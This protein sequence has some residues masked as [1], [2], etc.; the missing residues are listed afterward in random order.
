[1]KIIFN[2]SYTN[3][4]LKKNAYFFILL[5]FISNASHSQERCGTVP[6]SL[7]NRKI[8]VINERDVQFEQWLVEKIKFRKDLEKEKRVVA[9]SHKIQVI[10]HIIH[11]G[12]SVGAGTN[13]SDEQVFSQIAVLN[14]DFKR[15]NK[16]AV[17]TPAEF[18]SLAG[19]SSI[20]FVLAQTDPNGLPSKGINRIKGLMPEY[21]IEN[22]QEL[23]AQSYWPA[24]NYLNIWVC[25]LSDRFGYT[26]FP[27]STLPGLEN[28]SK[29]R[30]TDGI[31]ISFEVFGSTD[32]GNFQLHPSYVKG[33]TT[34]HEMGHF[35][36]LRHI[37]GDKPDCT[38]DD[39][40]DDTPIQSTETVGCPAHPVKE[41]PVSNPQS[42]MF[43][44]FL[45]YTDDICMNL[46]TK[47]QIER[48]I[49][50]LENSP[51]RAS[52]LIPLASIPPEVQFPKLFSPNG[53]GINDYWLWTNTLNYEGCKVSIFNRFGKLVYE[54]TSYDNTWDGRSSGGQPL[55]EEAYYYIISCENKKEITGAV[56]IV[57]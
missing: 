18:Q 23:K 32:D 33:R 47:G 53:D 14:K 15:Q 1:M 7:Q 24:E 49:T 10:V 13:I 9:I 44:N 19:A 16:D 46:F 5:F 17:N 42:K 29:S 8:G 38:G 27:V 4:S 35:L 12:E 2:S 39:H 34:T 52:L 51:R 22:D 40:V 37:W 43:Q 36:G 31:V 20:E 54:I 30:L 45:D 57:R 28:S 50:V 26:Q 55:E 3:Q 56:R 6:Y 11:N 21:T 25:N 41:C 48:M